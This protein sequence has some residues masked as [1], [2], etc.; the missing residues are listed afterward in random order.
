MAQGLL[1][2]REA[3]ERREATILA[4]RVRGFSAFSEET[5]PGVVFETLDVYLRA[6]AEAV[7]AEGGL[8]DT[9]SGDGVLAV[10]GVL[11][12]AGPSGVQAVRAATRVGQAVRDVRTGTERVSPGT[13]HAT[14]GI[15]SGPVALSVVR[16][17]GSRIV[18]A[19]GYRV[20]LAARLERQARPWEVVIDSETFGQLGEGRAG[21]QRL[22]VTGADLTEPAGA[23]SRIL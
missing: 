10:F 16:G 2:L 11:P 22:P 21:F 1:G 19:V 12:G 8:V 15:A 23:Y 20:D 18:N 3:G 5:P 7:L 4:A 6:L 17:Q 9:L 13:F 14:A